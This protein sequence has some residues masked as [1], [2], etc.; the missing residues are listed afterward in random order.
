MANNTREYLKELINFINKTITCYYEYAPSDI[1]LDYVVLNG[2]NVINFDDYDLLSFYLDVFIDENLPDATEKL[3]STCDKLRS[4]LDKHILNKVNMFNSHIYFDN[5][6]TVQ[7][8][9]FDLTHRRLSLS[10][11]IFYF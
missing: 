1:I 3:E 2:V 8:N 6:N 5:Q 10:A 9:E 11:R 4:L 7:E